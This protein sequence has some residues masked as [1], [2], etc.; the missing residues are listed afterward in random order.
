MKAYLL[1]LIFVIAPLIL[2]PTRAMAENQNLGTVTHPDGSVTTYDEKNCKKV[3][4]PGHPQWIC[5]C[6]KCTTE[7]PNVEINEPSMALQGAPECS[8]SEGQDIYV[9]GKYVMCSG[10]MPTHDDDPGKGKI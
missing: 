6:P 9:D 5:D 7:C 3:D 2:A 10:D 4:C 8:L 1:T